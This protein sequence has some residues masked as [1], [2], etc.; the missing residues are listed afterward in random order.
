MTTDKLNDY[1]SRCN[2]L[3]LRPVLEGLYI[4]VKDDEVVIDGISEEYIQS[5]K[6]D[7]RD[8]TYTF[9]EVFDRI[10]CVAGS[11]VDNFSKAMQDNN[12]KV[13]DLCNIKSI[14][15]HTVFGFVEDFGPTKL[16]ANNFDRLSPI[17]GMSSVKELYVDNIQ[18]LTGLGQYYANVMVL[19][20]KHMESMMNGV[21][22]FTSNRLKE[23][24]MDD[25]KYVA[26]GS[27]SLF[28]MLDHI[29]IIYMPSLISGSVACYNKKELEYVDFSSLKCCSRLMFSGCTSL[30]KIQLDSVEYLDE[31]VFK[32][33]VSLTRIS[34]P[35]LV[36]N[37]T[38]GQ[39][40]R[41]ANLEEVYLPKVDVLDMSVF[42]GCERLKKV[43]VSSKCRVLH[44][45][46]YKS[47]IRRI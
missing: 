14:N 8:G 37:C 12:V 46:G 22:C 34:L 30:K 13:L 35:N 1:I 4:K 36:G 5:V 27:V 33:C 15:M 42:K 6:Q 21:S 39:F 31:M 17:K 3:G 40:L 16:I 41:C 11:N 28:Y 2:L 47:T 32:G 44:T 10:E 9:S 38:F 43:V 29:K 45:T 7:T 25:L 19:H 23:I 20:S 18:E 26:T 24:Y